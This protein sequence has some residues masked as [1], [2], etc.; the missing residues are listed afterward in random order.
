MCEWSSYPAGMGYLSCMGLPRN[1]TIELGVQYCPE[2]P[3]T[4]QSSCFQSQELTDPGQTTRNT[5]HHYASTTQLNSR[6]NVVTKE[7]F[8]KPIR[9]PDC[10]ARFVIPKNSF[11][12]LHSP[13]TVS[14]TP[15]Q[16][17][18]RILWS[19][20]WLVSDCTTMESQVF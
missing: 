18:L 1:I 15:L 6:H 12:H 3:H 8:A 19:D 17:M 2:C 13:M 5:P 14:S 20:V 4:S 10:K 11:P 9:L 16:S 7:T